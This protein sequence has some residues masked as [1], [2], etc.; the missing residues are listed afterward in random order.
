MML[1]ISK[2]Q[3]QSFV[4]LRSIMSDTNAASCWICLDDGPDATGRPPM[5]DCSCRGSDAGFAHISC[6]AKWA[7]QQ[8]S[9]DRNNIRSQGYLYDFQA[10]WIEC[11][12][13]KQSLQ[14]HLKQELTEEFVKFTEHKYS[15]S[16]W[17]RLAAYS[18]KLSLEVY[19]EEL[20]RKCLAICNKLMNGDFDGPPIHPNSIELL[21]CGTFITTGSHEIVRA[22]ANDDEGAAKQGIRRLESSREIFKVAGDNDLFAFMEVTIS[23]RTTQCRDKWGPGFSETESVEKLLEKLK[24]YYEVSEGSWKIFSGGL[25][26]GVLI[27]EGHSTEASRLLSELIPLCQQIHGAEHKETIDLKELLDKV[28][29]P[30]RSDA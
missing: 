30:E 15:D 13:C 6:I 4:D 27:D 10:P 17:R 8:C 29:L 21:I 20:A 25:Y 9:E 7:K 28:D 1:I 11:F 26:A 22:I 5:R 23:S 12:Q 2:Q 16:D 19:N 14:G 3:L 18:G 24:A